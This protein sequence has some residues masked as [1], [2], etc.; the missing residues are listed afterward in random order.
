MLFYKRLSE[1]TLKSSQFYQNSPVPTKK[2]PRPT[3]SDSK[4][5]KV[6]CHKLTMINGIS[7]T[8]YELRAQIKTDHFGH[9]NT[10]ALLREKLQA[11]SGVFRWTKRTNNRIINRKNKSFIWYPLKDLYLGLGYESQVS[12]TLIEL[13]KKREI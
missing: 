1:F 7:D 5:L 4:T 8:S 13:I 9:K 12:S 10:P 11:I 3:E 2:P 6:L